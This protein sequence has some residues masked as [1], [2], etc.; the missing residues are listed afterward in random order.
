[1]KIKK[2]IMSALLA[3]ILGLGTGL[4]LSGCS[5]TNSSLEKAHIMNGGCFITCYN[6]TENRGTASAGNVNAGKR[7]KNN[8]RL[9]LRNI[10]HNDNS[11]FQRI[12]G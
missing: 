4:M 5:G 8:T 9:K 10:K 3:G 11:D 1:M 6:K 2:I 7:I 12:Y